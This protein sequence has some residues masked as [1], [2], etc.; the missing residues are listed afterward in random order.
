MQIYL[1]TL[2]LFFIALYIALLGSLSFW[3]RAKSLKTYWS[4]DR[5]TGTSMLTLSIVST[6]VG[7]GMV[8][9]I[10]SMAYIGG[11][12]PLFLGLFNTAGLL[13]VAVLAPRLRV[14]AEKHSMYSL[15]DFLGSIFSRRCRL[16]GAAVNLLVYFFFLAA[17]LIALS[18]ICSMLTGIGYIYSLSLALV[19]LIAYTFIGGMRTDIIADNIQFFILALLIII[20]PCSVFLGG[21]NLPDFSSLS[22]SYL[23]G[24]AIG[25]WPF[26]IG[27]LLF[28]T[29]VPLVQTDIWMRIYS[30]KS[31]EAARRSIAISAFLILPF[32]IVFTVMGITAHLL[33][34]QID[35]NAAMPQLISYFLMPGLK[36]I[37][38]AGLL[39]AIT[40]T[41]DSMLLISGMTVSKDIIC[42]ISPNIEKNERKLLRIARISGATIA[43]LAV[44]FALAVPN[45]VQTMVNAFSMLM[46]LLPSVLSGL[47]FKKK[48]E[49][50]SFWSIVIGLA[51]TL[52]MFL[53][54]PS[55]AFVPGVL[56]ALIVFAGLRFYNRNSISQTEC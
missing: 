20:L 1:S 32:F 33:F 12:V 27:L 30:A 22:S 46:I 2:D 7:S 24:E 13:L 48:D 36:G 31:P 38:I 15:P 9:G 3:I 44:V 23:M 21:H 51:V 43:V 11:L 55:M 40:S 19:I 41:A 28:Y 26:I 54:I 6:S 47:F 35:S 4:N 29:P 50:A 14:L 37:A 5:A 49:S 25:G 53:V 56:A 18:T 16:A 52:L 34:P 45:I 10:A 42:V 17:Q 8:F 39:A